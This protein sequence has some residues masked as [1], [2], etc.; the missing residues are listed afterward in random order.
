MKVAWWAEGLWPSQ[1]DAQIEVKANSSVMLVEDPF[2]LD[3]DEVLVENE[4]FYWRLMGG[5]G[6]RRGLERR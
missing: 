5:R 4:N 3:D 6:M 2:A 1:P